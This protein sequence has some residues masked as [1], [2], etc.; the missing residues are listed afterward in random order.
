MKFL[1]CAVLVPVLGMAALRVWAS[2]RIRARE[3]HN[4]PELA[5]EGSFVRV[6]PVNTHFIRKGKGEPLILIHGIFA[7]AFVWRKNLDALGR[8]F[9]TIAL[10]LKGY[11]YS[12]KPED[13]NYTQEAMRDF[14]AGFMDAIGVKRAVLVGHSWGGGIAMDLALRYSERVEK[15]VLI[16]STGY[17]PERSWLEWLL[18]VPGG[19][20]LLLSLLDERTMGKV[21]RERVFFDPAGVTDEEIA[22][23]VKPYRVKGAARAAMALRNVDF[24][25]ED[26]IRHVRQPVLILWGEN[27][28]TFPVEMARRF[29]RDLPRAT[30]H[31][32]PRCGHNPQEEKPEEVNRRI[33]EFVLSS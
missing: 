30:L 22:G 26:R 23:W 20:L 13:G 14:V 33:T 27:D 9:D 8:C 24:V 5:T 4:G 19:G 17:R 3:T 7:S 2:R 29:A 10:D 31:V 28:R 6:G 21:L 32:I 16:N 11:G 12:D 18:K 25:M 15:L 1:L